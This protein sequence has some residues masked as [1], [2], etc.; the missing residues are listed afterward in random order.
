MRADQ[1]STVD[2]LRLLRSALSELP[3][4]HRRYL[5]VQVFKSDFFHLWH[6]AEG[7]RARKLFKIWSA[8]ITPRKP[9][10]LAEYTDKAWQKSD[11]FIDDWLSD[12]M[13]LA[14]EVDQGGAT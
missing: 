11:A 6:Q 4:P 1:S 12:L 13:R 14:L 10:Q 8:N 5:M 9:G 2:D 7:E 3:S